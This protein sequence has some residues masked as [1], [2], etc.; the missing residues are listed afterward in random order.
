MCSS[1]SYAVTKTSSHKSES[2]H[3][4][5]R[6]KINPITSEGDA[7]TANAESGIYRA[8]TYENI[9]VG[10]STNNGWDF[11][12]SLINTQI[13]GPDKV[14]HGDLFFNVAKTF[15]IIKELSVV[16][17]SQNGFSMVNHHPRLWYNYDYVDTRYEA[18][19][20]LSLHGGVYLA[21]AEITGVYRQVGYLTGTELTFIPHKL[22][23]QLDYVSGHQALSGATANIVF[24]ITPKFQT[25][26]GVYVPEQNSGNEFAGIIGFN[27]SSKNF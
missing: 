4:Q 15:S 6:L 8:G 17:G 22:S 13:I 14:F 18:T 21:N 5:K 3:K 16:V 27:L 2:Q 26:F 11:S 20:W 25:Y 1:V 9:G 24:T 23:L 12:V 19:P 10:Y 7:W